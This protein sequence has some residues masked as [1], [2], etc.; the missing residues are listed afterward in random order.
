MAASTSALHE[1]AARVRWTGNRGAGTAGYAAYGRRYDVLV[2]GKPDLAGSAHAAFRGDADRHDP[3][4]LF[5]ASI[6]ACHMLS[7]LA[8]CAR[9]GVRVTSYEDHARGTLALHPGGGGR[10]EEVV[11]RPAVTVADAETAVHAE[12]LHDAAHGLCFIAGS[13]SVP[14]R[15]EPVVRVG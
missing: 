12:R 10:F 13:C 7:Y 6:S 15:V 3:E 1:Y 4:D 2:D 14:I 9:G 11:L 8:L 5:L